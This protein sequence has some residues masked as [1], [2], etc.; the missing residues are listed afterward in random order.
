[1][2]PAYNLAFHAVL[3]APRPMMDVVGKSLGFLPNMLRTASVGPAILGAATD[4]SSVLAG[5]LGL[6]ACGQI[7]RFGPDEVAM[8]RK[9]CSADPKVDLAVRFAVANSRGHVDDIENNLLNS[10]VRT[11]IDLS[12]RNTGVGVT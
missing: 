2:T 1:M 7:A 8:N 10:V 6:K 4:L 5:T 9:G 12:F 3:D 11:K